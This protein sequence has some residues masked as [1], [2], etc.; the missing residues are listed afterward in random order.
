MT[1]IWLGVIAVSVA[2]LAVCQA[3]LLVA[4]LRAASRVERIAAELERDIKP[5]IANLTA[6]SGDAAKA[7][8]LAA[9]QAERLDRLFGDFTARLDKG[10]ALA[11]GLVG[12]PARNGVALVTGIRAAV[13]AFRGIREATRRR[14]AA[15]GEVL[16]DESLFIG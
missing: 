15:A 8:S 9:T 12:G 7:A 2:L 3:A 6:A 10:L 16:D 4:A 1:D 11:A 5:L 14:R 13:A